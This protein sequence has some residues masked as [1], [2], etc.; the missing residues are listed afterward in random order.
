MREFLASI[1]ALLHLPSV[2]SSTR[3]NRGHLMAGLVVVS[4]LLGGWSH[5]VR[6]ADGAVVAAPSALDAGG[7]PDFDSVTFRPLACS[8]NGDPAGDENP[9]ST[10]LVGDA[11]HS[12][13]YFAW[14]DSYLYFRFRV[15]SN[16]TGA[17]GFDQYAW[18]VLLQVPS[19]DPFQ[20]QFEL[21]LNGKGSDDDFGNASGQKGDTIEIWR[22]DSAAPAR[23]RGAAEAQRPAPLEARSAHDHLVPHPH[24]AHRRSHGCVAGAGLLR[25]V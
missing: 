5:E 22:N 17:K 4:T 15:T 8:V 23:N 10:D 13:T 12:P 11:T 14:D 19:G 21:A 9:A 7:G 2:S 25:Q 20:H 18:V 1:D 3:K 24:V 6:A 16:P